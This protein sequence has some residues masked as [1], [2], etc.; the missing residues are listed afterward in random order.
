MSLVLASASATRAA[1]LTGAGLIFK[2]IPADVDERLFEAELVGLP[3][4]AVAQALADAKALE[5][6]MRRPGDLVI[7]ADQT[8]ALGAERFH[9]P[10]SRS[11]A[12]R[13]LT[14]LSGRTHDLHSALSLARNGEVLHRAVDSASLTM[15][16]LSARFIGHYLSVVGDSV[17]GCVGAYQLEGFGV[18]LFSKVD[19][20]HFTVLGL[21]LLPLL[22]FLREERM[23]EQ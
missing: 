2:R 13:Q 8:L 4:D 12:Q 19:G 21:P 1:L 22:A 9:K 15:R 20:N 10:V 7:G 3:P 17:L 14:R 11:D 5:V 6:S 16:P 18:Q 23:I